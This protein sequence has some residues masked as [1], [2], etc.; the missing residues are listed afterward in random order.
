VVHVSW[1]DAVAYCQWAGTRLPNEAQ[2]ERAARGGLEGRRFAWGDDL[3][4]AHGVPLF[5]RIEAIYK[6][7]DGLNL[8]CHAN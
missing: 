5:T 7:T 4:D 8:F 6:R 3:F 2:W 1:N